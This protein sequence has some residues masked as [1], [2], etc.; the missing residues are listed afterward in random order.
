MTEQMT[1]YEMQTYRNFNDV[2]AME[3]R[4]AELT[5]DQWDQVMAGFAAKV[6]DAERKVEEATRYRPSYAPAGVLTKTEG[7]AASWLKA[8]RE[9]YRF[10]LTIRAHSGK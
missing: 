6:A 10:W 2:R 5:S 7:N 1:A 4:A 3:V 8:Q 9:Q